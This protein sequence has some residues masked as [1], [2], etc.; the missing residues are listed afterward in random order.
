MTQVIWLE[1]EILGIVSKTLNMFQENY[2]KD[3][4]ALSNVQLKTHW[5]SNWNRTCFKPKLL[6][7]I[8]ED[9]NQIYKVPYANAICSLLYVTLCTRLGIRFSTIMVSRFQSKPRHFHCQA[10]KRAS[11][12]FVD[13][14]IC[15]TM[16]VGYTPDRL[17]TLPR[18]VTKMSGSPV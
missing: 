12:I 8:D 6:P 16:M 9:K 11:G 1:L 18:P 17:A 2:I 5:H 4:W 14:R 3:L 13:V 10:L 15:D 7:K